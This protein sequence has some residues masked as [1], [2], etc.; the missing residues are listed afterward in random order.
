MPN[1][2][3]FND[4]ASQLKTQIYGSNNGN[5][6]P[7]ST[8][9]NGNITLTATD[10][11]IRDLSAD[12]DSV[13]VTATDLDIRD[14]SAD[15]D[16]VTVTATDL[17]IR[18]LSADT[19]SVTVTATDLDIR[20]LSGET[21]SIIKA[22]SL[23]TESNVTL[24]DITSTGIALSIDTSQQ[25]IYSFYVRNTGAAS[26]SVKLQISPTD[27]DD[28][29]EDDSSSEVALDAGDRAILVAQR[30]LKYTRVYY[31]AS[32]TT[33]IEAYYNAHA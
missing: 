11:D 10:L 13:T 28:Y 17:D 14:L 24:E 6:V 21:D 18:D 33:T 8:D 23:F 27:S 32:D 7:I 25:D 16:S 4:V 19:D 15:T 1:N 31:N 26:V 5:I 12:T 29:F 30:Y 3:V 20:N 9:E 2:I 22:G